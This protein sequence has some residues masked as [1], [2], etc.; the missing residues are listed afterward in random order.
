MPLTEPGPDPRLSATPAGPSAAGPAFEGMYS[1][2]QVS[3]CFLAAK[4][5]R[6]VAMYAG[7]RAT[8]SGALSGPPLH[9][10]HGGELPCREGHGG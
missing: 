10:S 3:T 6:T 1:G 9:P 5:A 7:L 4:T 2:R 8:G